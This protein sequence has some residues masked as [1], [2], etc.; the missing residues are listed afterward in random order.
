MGESDG[1]TWPGSDDRRGKGNRGS[2]IILLKCSLIKSR[3]KKVAKH[4]PAQ[5]CQM[6]NMY[7]LY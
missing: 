3:E 4:T 5:P 6:R 1:A 7:A 2:I